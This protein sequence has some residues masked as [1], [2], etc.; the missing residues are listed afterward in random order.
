MEHSKRPDLTASN[1]DLNRSLLQ[2]QAAQ[3]TCIVTALEL[4]V[5]SQSSQLAFIRYQQ[6]RVALAL[7]LARSQSNP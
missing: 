3:T 2:V 7:A 6:A 1:F 4:Q 5:V